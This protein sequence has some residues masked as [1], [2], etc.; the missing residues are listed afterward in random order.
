MPPSAPSA[1]K[2]GRRGRRLALVAALVPGAAGLVASVNVWSNPWL[3]AL[4]L[5]WIAA[6][7]WRMRGVIAG[8]FAPSPPS[9][10]PPELVP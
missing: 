4:S 10:T 9:S 6:V 7:V 1:P 5:A 3:L 8:E 2:P